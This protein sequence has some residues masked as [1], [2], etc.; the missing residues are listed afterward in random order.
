MHIEE[1][2][3]WVVV[4]SRLEVH[5]FEKLL[6]SYQ[7]YRLVQLYSSSIFEPVPVNSFILKLM[8]RSFGNNIHKKVL[9]SVWLKLYSGPSFMPNESFYNSTIITRNKLQALKYLNENEQ[10]KGAI[11]HMQRLYYIVMSPSHFGHWVHAV[12]STGLSSS[13]AFK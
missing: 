7:K 3:F 9:F 13:P 8:E 1:Q 11:V 6:C 4:G 10:L 5:T 12:H 2:Y